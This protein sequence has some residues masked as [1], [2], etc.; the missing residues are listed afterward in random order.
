MSR[1]DTGTDDPRVRVRPGRGS[2]P[3][4][5]VRPDW[6]E[7]PLG[8]VVSIDRGRYGVVLADPEGTRLIG[9]RARE[10]GRG[11]LVL[12]D[13]VRMTGDLSGRPDTLAR[14]VAIED[15]STVLRRSRDDAADERSEKAIVANAQVMVVVVAAADPEPRTGMVD[16]CLVAAYE[17]GLEPVL[18]VTKSDL[19]DPAPFVARFSPFGL[20]SVAVSLLAPETDGDEG[21]GKGEDEGEGDRAD[22]GLDR[23]RD[24]LA[25]RFSVLVGHSGVGKSTLINALVPGA[26][27]ATGHVNAVTGRGRHTSTSAEAFELPGGGW[28]ADTPG[29][30]SFGLGHVSADDILAVFPD[31]AEAASWCLPMCTHAADEPSC[32]LDAWAVGAEPFA[33]GSGALDADESARRMARVAAVRRLL[34]SLRAANPLP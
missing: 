4:S 12:G 5:K 23:L 17:A 7:Q 21:K 6:S 10:L 32:A 16:R 15:R 28:V 31:V 33:R 20:T 26:G 14:I 8:R 22:P 34:A 2:R 24:L 29:V 13:R 18:C 3:R 1:R 27:R 19:A 9:V 30:R 11:S 25:D